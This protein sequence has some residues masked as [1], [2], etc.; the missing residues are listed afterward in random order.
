L[1]WDD[2]RKNTHGFYLYYRPT[3]VTASRIGAA[4]VDGMDVI[5]MLVHNTYISD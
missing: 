4:P 3:G 5:S 1:S 2:K